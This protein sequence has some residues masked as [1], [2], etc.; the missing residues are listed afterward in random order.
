[1]KHGLY[2]NKTDVCEYIDREI[3]KHCGLF[4]RSIDVNDIRSIVKD[5]IRNADS[6][7]LDEEICEELK[8]ECSS[9][10]SIHR[11]LDG[12]YSVTFLCHC[13]KNER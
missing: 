2:V 6:L 11:N 10:Y 8:I 13:R 4:R 1:M 3:K 7:I 5:A 12:T 9:L